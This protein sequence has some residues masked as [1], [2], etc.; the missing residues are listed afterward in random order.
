[1]DVKYSMQ[2]NEKEYSAEEAAAATKIQAMWKGSY[3]R[4][5][6]KARTPGT[7]FLLFIKQTVSVKKKL[8]Y[9][10]MKRFHRHSTLC[11]R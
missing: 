9:V 11:A 2:A 4:S 5:L 10:P 7:T 6:I 3:L 8:S 1:M